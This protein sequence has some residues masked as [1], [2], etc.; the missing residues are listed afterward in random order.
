MEE[1]LTAQEALVPVLGN[2]AAA[3]DAILDET[4]TVGLITSRLELLDRYLCMFEENHVVLIQAKTPQETP[5]FAQG[6]HSRM[7]AVYVEAGGR[8]FDAEARLR[9]EASHFQGL[10]PL[11]NRTQLLLQQPWNFHASQFRSSAAAAK[12]G[13]PSE[14]CAGP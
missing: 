11:A 12:I 13:S 3:I 7:E 1:V 9:P 4:W 6:T 5:Y 2:T 14:T 8:L 10:V